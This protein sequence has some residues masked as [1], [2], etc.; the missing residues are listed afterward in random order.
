MRG[1]W[2]DYVVELNNKLQGHPGG[3]VAAGLTWVMT[4]DGPNNNATHNAV[5]NCRYKYGS[6]KRKLA[7]A[8]SL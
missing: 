3:S 5:A 7:N 4:Q 1:T 6:M 8:S 2:T